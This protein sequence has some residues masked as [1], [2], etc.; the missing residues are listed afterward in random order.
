[1]DALPADVSALVARI[2][3]WLSLVGT[4]GVIKSAAMTGGMLD[5]EVEL[6][7]PG[8]E[9]PAA[10]RLAR[11]DRL[12]KKIEVARKLYRFY[13]PDLSRAASPQILSVA[14][15][16]RLCGLLLRTALVCGDARY[17]NSALKLLDG[18]L[19]R[20]DCVFPDEL[21]VLA[22]STLDAMVPLAPL[23]A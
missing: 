7:R 17:L 13:L 8:W 23:A 9:K 12:R 22:R 20:D 5:L 10:D 15:V 21:R 11:L 6:S 4:D 1:M 3:A 2:D 16:L 18:V 14:A 19:E